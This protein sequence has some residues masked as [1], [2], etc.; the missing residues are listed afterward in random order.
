MMLATEKFETGLQRKESLPQSASWQ[1]ICVVLG[2][3][4]PPFVWAN[5]RPPEQPSPYSKSSRSNHRLRR[6]ADALAPIRPAGV[7]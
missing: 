7:P 2:A 4:Q 6:R 5:Y 1:T 3:G